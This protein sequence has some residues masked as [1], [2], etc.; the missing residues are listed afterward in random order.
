MHNSFYHTI[1]R[2]KRECWETFL[3]D[4][5][6]H[7]S[8][9]LGLEDSACCWQALKYTKPT[10]TGPSPALTESEPECHIATTVEEKAA[11]ITELAFPTVMESSETA[12]HSTAVR[13]WHLQIR[14]N[15]VQKALFTQ[16]SQ[17]A[18]GADRINFKAL[19]M[20]WD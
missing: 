8:T 18:P 14:K 19:R 3:T 15:T 6:D 12:A 11:L 9:K 5:K 2:V 16:A 17:K 10:E 20:L 1:H 7:Q 4:N 13:Y